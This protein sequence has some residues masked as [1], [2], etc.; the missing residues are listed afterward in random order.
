M[1]KDKVSNCC[2]APVEYIHDDKTDGFVCSKCDR[3]CDAIC[4]F[5]EGTGEVSQMESVYPGEPHMADIGTRKCI[6]KIEEDD[7]DYDED[8]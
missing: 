1:E 7:E 4:E 5:C 3:L 2:K 8:F 6:C